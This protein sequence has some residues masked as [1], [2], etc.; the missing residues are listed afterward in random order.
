MMHDTLRLLTIEQ[1]LDALHA[2][3]NALRGE[4]HAAQA[5]IVVLEERA[6]NLEA[7]NTVRAAYAAPAIDIAALAD[8]ERCYSCGGHV[9]TRQVEGRD[10]WMVCQNCGAKRILLY[11]AAAGAA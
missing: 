5:R 9:M 7:A 4:L 2:A 3:L 11:A 6:G 1:G 8:A 10:V